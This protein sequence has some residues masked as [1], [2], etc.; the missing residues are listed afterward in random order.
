MQNSKINVILIEDSI[1][2]LAAC[3]SIL[4]NGYKGKICVIEKGKSLKDRL[5]NEVCCGSFGAGTYS[6]S[7]ISKSLNV[8]GIIPGQTQEELD[9]YGDLLLSYINSFMLTDEEPLT[10]DKNNGFDTSPSNLNWESNECCHVGSD[11][12]R[13]LYYSIEGYLT[14]ITL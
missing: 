10:W 13:R 11:R 5:P 8:G 14:L 12:G 7:K 1:K 9:H 3:I 4:E 2:K 6:D